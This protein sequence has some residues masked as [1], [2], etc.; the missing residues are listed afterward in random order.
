ML[1]LV[2]LI[3][4]LLALI[5]DLELAVDQQRRRHQ[6]PRH[7]LAVAV[8]LIGRLLKVCR[9]NRLKLGA[10]AGVTSAER[11]GQV[12]VNIIR[13]RRDNRLA[14]LLAGILLIDVLLALLDLNLFGRLNVG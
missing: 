3:D 6:R 14:L 11:A 13:A 10:D 2:V 1:V 5:L 7:H 4:L 8:R 9:G 12:D